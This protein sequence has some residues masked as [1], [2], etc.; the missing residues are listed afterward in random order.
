MVGVCEGVAVSGNAGKGVRG[1][2]RWEFADRRSEIDGKRGGSEEMGDGKSGLRSDWVRPSALGHFRER[3]LEAI[4]REGRWSSWRC[5]SPVAAEG[6][7]RTSHPRAWVTQWNLG[8]DLARGIRLLT[9]AATTGLLPHFQP[10]HRS[11]RGGKLVRFDSHALEHGDEE[12][13]QRIVALAVEGE[14]LAMLEATT[15][16]ENG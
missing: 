15:T 11:G 4:V 3:S 16:E 2:R 1:G 7:R 6:T 8:W 14:V 12:I 13:W 10:A 9:A 5:R